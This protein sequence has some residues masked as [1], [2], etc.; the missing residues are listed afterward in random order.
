MK[1]LTIIMMTPNKVPKSWAR[2]HKKML[3]EA[4]GDTK[5]ITISSIPLSWGT[6]LIQTEYGVDNLFKQ[7]LRGCKLA[8]T[9]YIAIADDDTL[10]PKEHF[11]YRPPPD[12]F[13]Y[14]LNRWHLFTWGEPFYFHKP[15]P[16]NGLM[17]ASR[18]LV[19]NAIERRLNTQSAKK[20]GLSRFLASELGTKEYTRKYDI[21]EMISFYTKSPVVS[22]YHE[23]SIDPL[24]QSRKK[25][26]WPVRAYDIPV[27]GK[28]KKIRSR[29]K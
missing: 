22:F 24:N 23:M 11:E 20:R 9:P 14:N 26:P 25:Y 27:W 8:T 5:I 21:G 3:L 2:Y 1:D 7:M 10:Y 4:V 12:K 13:G 17:I 15:R 28:A 18:E 16:G 19:A 29:F 6:N